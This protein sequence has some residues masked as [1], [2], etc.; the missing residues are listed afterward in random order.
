[1]MV[2][3]KHIKVEFGKK[4]YSQHKEEKGQDTLGIRQEKIEIVKMI[5][6]GTDEKTFSG[7][8]KVNYAEQK[9]KE[10]YQKVNRMLGGN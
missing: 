9:I 3:T 4:V 7:Y 10:T 8:R 6:K 1:M 2:N 5:K